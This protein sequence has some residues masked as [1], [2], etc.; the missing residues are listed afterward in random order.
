MITGRHFGLGALCLSLVGLAIAAETQ[1]P[2]P[3]R[4]A[5]VSTPDSIP[6][7]EAAAKHLKRTACLKDAKTKKLVGAQRSAYVKTCLETGAST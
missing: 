5:Q 6:A 3:A 1:P 4:P 7:D 2:P